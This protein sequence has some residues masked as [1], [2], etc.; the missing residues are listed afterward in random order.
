M[1]KVLFEVI[2]EKILKEKHSQISAIQEQ[3]SR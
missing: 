2:V 3:D 1:N